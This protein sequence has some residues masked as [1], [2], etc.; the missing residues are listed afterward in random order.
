MKNLEELL[1]HADFVNRLARRLVFDA[2]DAADVAQETWLAG[3]RNPPASKE[4]I[5]T[6]LSHVIRNVASTMRR[7]ESRRLKREQIVSK[8]DRAPSAAD[9]VERAEIRHRVVEAVLSLAE[10]YRST[11]LLRFYEDFS[12]REIARS[13]DLPVETV[14]TRLKR[15]MA[16]L[17][18]KLDV[19][20]EGRRDAWCLA[21]GP[22][23]GLKWAAPIAAGGITKLS[24][25]LIMAS[26]LKIAVAVVL[27]AVA[28][29]VVWQIL[30]D[31]SDDPLILPEAAGD[32][33]RHTIA[34]VEEDGAAGGAADQD[35]GDASER[36]LE[37]V[38]LEPQGIV[39]SGRVIDAVTREPVH[40]FDLDL[41]R[42]AIERYPPWIDIAHETIENERGLFS[43]TT[44]D[45][46]HHRIWVRASTHLKKMVQLDIA[47][48]ERLVDV[49]IALDP[50]QAVTGRVIDAETGFPVASALVG[51]TQ[52]PGGSDLGWVIF[53]GH[54]EY[55]PHA[56]T[57]AQGR[58][59]L[60]GL[61]RGK[62]TI[63]ALHPR[64]A[65]GFVDADP[66]AGEEIEIRLE[67]G[68][69][70]RG[71]VRDDD[72]QPLPGIHV[73]L[74]GTHLPYARVAL[75]DQNGHYETGPA[76]HGWIH[77]ETQPPPGQAERFANFTV[78]S[79]NIELVD[80]DVRV[81][82]GPDQGHVT[83]RGTFYDY[84]GSPLNGAR[85]NVSRRHR[86]D[87][88]RYERLHETMTDAE[89]R[90]VLGK[91]LLKQYKVE[92]W[93]PRVAAK[94][95]WD[96]ISFDQPGTVER[97]I[98]VSGG[99]VHGVVVDDIS[100][101]RVDT[102]EGL[103]MAMTSTFPYKSFTCRLDDRGEFLLRGL[104]PEVYS[105]SCSIPDCPHPKIE[106]VTISSGDERIELRVAVSL[107]G[108]LR[109]RFDGFDGTRQRKF[110]LTLTGSDGSERSRRPRTLHVRGK[111]TE[112]VRA[113]PGEYALT[114]ASEGFEPLTRTCTI[115]RGETTELFLER[116]DFEKDAS[117]VQVAG[118]VRFADGSHAAGAFL[119]VSGP[120]Y[121]STTTDS[122]GGFGFEGMKP[123][124]WSVKVQLADGAECDTLDFTVPEGR[125][126]LH[127]VALVLPEGRVSGA[128]YDSVTD[129]PLSEDSARWFLTL[130][131]RST[132]EARGSV[133]NRRGSRFSFAGVGDGHY[134]L[135]ITAR[136]F[137]GR[138]TEPFY[139]L[140]GESVDLGKIALEPSGVLDVEVVD[141]HGVLV[142]IFSVVCGER[143]LKFWERQSL[144]SGKCRC[145]TLPLGEVSITISAEGFVDRS[146]PVILEPG[147]IGLL[148]VELE[149][150]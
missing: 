105:I 62:Q 42:H 148:R 64:F 84:D 21:L 13:E 147:R 60:R 149:G 121:L 109:L 65:E 14:R 68:F 31:Q 125:V 94:V 145:F 33:S 17:R 111:G 141:R 27:I 113:A 44:E 40:A 18:D 56:T 34:T 110:S 2:R 87:Y 75:S 132:N 26:K 140:G 15:G 119:F 46:G 133:G 120:D 79:K 58:F 37:K 50:G 22:I 92:I 25:G 39:I 63:A 142:P 93:Y 122:E 29:V 19:L 83:W 116:S 49:E 28:S 47:P 72:G 126:D 78:E 81:D 137:A 43:Y 23:V 131:D 95:E 144:S 11:I 3:M 70:L 114:I 69:R 106:P 97:D 76:L 143:K 128:L 48:G 98:V 88:P 12:P 1:T 123:G 77:V 134:F 99:I 36:A 24:G 100:G 103:M 101:E 45:S 57:D 66:A 74:W 82:F 130:V 32:G 61:E 118:S 30:D 86:Q 59:T 73:K 41:K 54:S 112:I 35:A 146:V 102:D 38:T 89:G 53:L 80:H 117:L 7:T 85:I 5:R 136:G 6:W 108:T 20:H 96:D 8:P 127:E 91:L 138:D 67:K 4:S 107:G 9:V 115:L 51:T 52:Y 139:L 124:V 104:G 150:E 10:P 135:S 129:Q 55:E 16:L 90:F 71:T